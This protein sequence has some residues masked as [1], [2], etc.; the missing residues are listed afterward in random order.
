VA[1][2]T[3]TREQSLE[4]ARSR[5][6]EKTVLVPFSDCH[7]FNGALNEHGYGILRIAGKNEKAHRAAFELANGPIPRGTGHHGTVVRHR[8][9]EPSCVNPDHLE[10]GTQQ[11]N[12]R[13]TRAR[14]RQYQGPRH[15][16]RKLS[17][18]SVRQIKSAFDRGECQTTIAARHDVNPSWVHMIGNGRVRRKAL[19]G[20]E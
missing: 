18:E 7:Y 5:L 11:D 8:C 15:H 10:L 17:G 1:P 12:L 16:A 6:S 13:D 9:D 20:G 19:A 2:P 4:T 14:D 3:L